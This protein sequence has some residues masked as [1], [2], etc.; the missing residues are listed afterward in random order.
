MSRSFLNAATVNKTIRERYA[1][2]IRVRALTEWITLC[3][4][5]LP[6]SSAL[7]KK[8]KTKTTHTHTK[9]HILHHPQLQI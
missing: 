9:T 5:S 4:S 8:G 6:G 1:Y 7:L 2:M 3:I